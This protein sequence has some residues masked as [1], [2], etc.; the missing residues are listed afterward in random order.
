[1]CDVCLFILCVPE[2][3][4]VNTTYQKSEHSSKK[5]DLQ[6]TLFREKH[7]RWTTKDASEA[8][9]PKQTSTQGSAV[10]IAQ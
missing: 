3:Y 9:K 1:M 8:Q 2:T 6:P 4:F 5:T 10:P 7:N